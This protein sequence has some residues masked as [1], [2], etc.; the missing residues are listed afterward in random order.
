M[1]SAGA[2]YTPEVLGLA[3]GLAA[4]PLA[5]DLP[6]HGRARSPACGSALELGL[7]L[8]AAGRIA[9]LG[10]KAH[11]CAIGQAAAAIFAAH[12]VGCT[13]EELTATL[14]A[15]EGWLAGGAQPDWPGIAAIAAARDF[16]G[17][18]GAMLLPWKAALDALCTAAAG[19]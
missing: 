3:T 10:I 9:R 19:R 2:L 11:S 6:L 15:L 14:T 1:A 7:E 5:D 13:R 12:A 8:D 17:R 18:H 4:F 16:P